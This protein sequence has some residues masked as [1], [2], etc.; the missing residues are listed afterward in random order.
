V[1]K[2]DIVK[3]DKLKE[4]EKVGIY[5]GNRIIAIGTATKGG[6]STDRVFN[7]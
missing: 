6:V 7:L 3:S 2:E 4:G 5:L 1:R